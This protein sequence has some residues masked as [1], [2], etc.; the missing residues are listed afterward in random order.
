PVSG[1]P[2]LKATPA[3]IASVGY[4][5]RGFLLTRRQVAMPEGWWWA[6]AAITGGWGAQ[7]ATADSSRAVAL[8]VRG[9]IQSE[10]LSGCEL[11]EYADH[12]RDRYRCAVYDGDR[13]VACL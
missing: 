8:T 3:A 7:F 6:R 9:L 13:L 5:A 12:A 4:R 1:Q 11:A 2:E 10:A